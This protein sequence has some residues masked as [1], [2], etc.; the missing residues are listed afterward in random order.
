MQNR[1]FMSCGQVLACAFVLAGVAFFA[2]CEGAGFKGELVSPTLTG[3]VVITGTAQVGHMLTANIA[4]L[5]GNGAISFQWRRG[6]ENVGTNG[7]TYLVQAADIGYSITVTVAR[8]GNSG[9]ITSPAVGPVTQAGLPDLTGNVTITGTPQV[10]QTLAA[11][12]A[13]LGGTGAI[14]FQWRRGGVNV[15]TNSNSYVVQAADVGQTITVTVT[16]A[17][18]SGNVT[19]LAVGPVTLP[20]LTGNVVITGTPQVGQTLTADTAGLGGTGVISFQWRRGVVNIGTNSNSYIVQASDVGQTI[21]VAVTRA[22]NSG[23]VTSPA[24]GPVTQAGLPDLTGSVTITGTPQVGQTL[25]ADTAG[26]GGAG[27][28][29]FQWRRNGAGVGTNSG[30][31]TVQVADI[32]HYITVTVTRAGNSGNITS[33]AIGPVVAAPHDPFY[34]LPFSPENLDHVRTSNVGN[35]VWDMQHLSDA[36]IIDHFGGGIGTNHGTVDA[37]EVDGQVVAFVHSFG[38]M[39]IGTNDPNGH[40]WTPLRFMA[41]NTDGINEGYVLYITGRIGP[42]P[43]PIAFEGSDWQGLRRGWVVIQ[44]IPQDE[45]IRIQP[46]TFTLRYVLTEA[47][48]A[49]QLS[50]GWNSWGDF[51]ASLTAGENP[52]VISVDDMV[53]TRPAPPPSPNFVR[54]PGGTFLMGS[55]EGTPNSYA[56]ERPVRQV[57]VSG[58]YMSKFTVTQGEW[59]DMKGTRPSFFTGET[60]YYGNPVTGV[61]WRNLPIDF[62]SWF[63]AVEFANAKS[64]LA[65]LTPAYTINGTTVTWNRHANGYRLPTEAEWEC[66]DKARKTAIMTIK[67]PATTQGMIS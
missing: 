24:V 1:N 39:G 67:C 8:A 36:G 63:D 55:L 26:L 13:G 38:G 20:P 25:T 27:A 45:N 58:F 48:L 32:G 19:S 42:D 6:D 46:G 2:A 4:G 7:G 30:S 10:G 56:N 61:N 15:G 28:I 50:I 40:N 11:N 23:N 29:S 12:T 37:R 62:A 54:V 17:G 51:G 47:D 64:L 57:T 22:G 9:N 60:D 33:P 35:I 65:G 43:F 52:L 3:N 49:A 44:E 14:S 18:H 53:I 41:P 34:D 59:Y 5:D 66:V 31:Y 21:T 16:R